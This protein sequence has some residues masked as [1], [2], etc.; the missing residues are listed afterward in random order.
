MDRKVGERARGVSAGG[1][2]EGKHG[3]KTVQLQFRPYSRLVL[4]DRGR[5][6]EGG[7]PSVSLPPLR[8]PETEGFPIRLWASAEGGGSFG[9]RIVTLEW[10]LWLGESRAGDRRVLAPRDERFG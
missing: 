10:V 7:S 9:A 1:E 2:H 5:V 3:S 6:F 4:P 8:R